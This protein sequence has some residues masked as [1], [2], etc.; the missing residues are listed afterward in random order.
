[1]ILT[2]EKITVTHDMMLKAGMSKHNQYG[3]PADPN[4][5]GKGLKW[6]TIMEMEDSDFDAIEEY[7][8]K[9]SILNHRP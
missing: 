2:E 8:L 3:I 7:F 5:P 6:K 1:M 4:D 9:K